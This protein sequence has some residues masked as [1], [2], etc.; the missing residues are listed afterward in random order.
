MAIV[1]LAC[2]IGLLHLKKWARETTLVYGWIALAW[3]I[4]GTIITAILFS[5]NLSGAS[6]EELP[7]VVGSIIGGM[8]GGLVG[9]IYP[10]ILIVYMRKP[11]VV[12]ACQK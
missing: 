7:V 4:L 5:S 2:G 9:L 3:G 6:Q 8:C 1:L 12:E 11:H 10:V